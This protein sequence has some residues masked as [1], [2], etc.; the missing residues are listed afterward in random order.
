[1]TEYE[2]EKPIER[3]CGTRELGG[4]Y[5]V[6]GGLSVSCD[7]LPFD[8]KRCKVCG[9]GF[10]QQRNFQWIDWDRYAGHHKGKCKC[11]EQCA[12]CKPAKGDN[13]YG[14][15]WVGKR[16]YTPESFI[17]E[18]ETVGIS[19]RIPWVPK[20]LTLG[21]T[22]VLL[23]HPMAG[24]KDSEDNDI[25]AIFYA[26]RPTRVEKLVSEDTSEEKLNQFKRRGITPILVRKE[27]TKQEKL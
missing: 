10:K 24:G 11:Y 19:K 1:M 6:G 12:I 4:M 22:W 14:L 3:G 15:L 20:E 13:N 8:I 2:Y 27:E 18:A 23:A 26:F 5:L 17:K 7:R 25:P 21:M 9:G 16:Y